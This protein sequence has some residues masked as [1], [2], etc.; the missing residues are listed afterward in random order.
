MA[1]HG[2]LHTFR[3][4]IIGADYEQGMVQRARHAAKNAEDVIERGQFVEDAPRRDLCV[5]DTLRNSVS[6]ALRHEGNGEVEQHPRQRRAIVH[7]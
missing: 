4:Y 5:K 3:Q 7:R 6:A 2:L 1:P